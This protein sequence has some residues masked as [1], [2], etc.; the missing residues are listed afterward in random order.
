MFNKTP[1]TI[2]QAMAP[3]NKIVADLHRVVDENTEVRNKKLAEIAEAQK[4]VKAADEQITRAES[5]LQTFTL[6][7]EGVELAAVDNATVQLDDAA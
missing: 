3:I 5:G 1:Y 2:D 4:A 7:Q 6:L